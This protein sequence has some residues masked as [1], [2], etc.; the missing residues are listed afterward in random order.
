C[1]R[2]QE[3]SG[4]HITGGQSKIIVF[5][6][7]PTEYLAETAEPPEQASKTIADDRLWS[8]ELAELRRIAVGAGTRPVTVRER[9]ALARTRS[10]AVR[11]YILRRADST[12]EGCGNLAPFVTPTGRP[13]LEPH[14]IRR[15]TDGGAE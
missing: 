3:R 5:E 2:H 14:H 7:V 4:P 12:C 10:Q 9:K 13:Y 8:M 11:V 15:L 1:E 6:L